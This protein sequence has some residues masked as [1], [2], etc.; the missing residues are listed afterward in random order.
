MTVK[1]LK[2]KLKDLP[3]DLE[4]ATLYTTPGGKNWAKWTGVDLYRVC[5][6][7]NGTIAWDVN[8]SCKEVII[9]N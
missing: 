4:I 8:E 5:V 3:D 6:L 9:L 1:D 2:E 7:K